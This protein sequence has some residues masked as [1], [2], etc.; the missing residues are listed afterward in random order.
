MKLVVEHKLNEEQEAIVEERIKELYVYADSRVDDIRDYAE[1]A[2][3]ELQRKV[4]YTAAGAAVLGFLSGV[5]V[6][7]LAKEIDDG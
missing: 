2:I 3:E 5:I 4:L 1:E 6:G 7:H